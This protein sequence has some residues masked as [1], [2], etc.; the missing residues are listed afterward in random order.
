M[1]VAEIGDEGQTRLERGVARVG[2]DGFAHEI[3]HVYAARGGVGEILP[4][5]VDEAS[6]APPFL[7][8]PAARATVAGSRAA[9]AAMRDA[10]GLSHG[11]RSAPDSHRG[12]GAT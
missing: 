11:A 3:A 2:G 4:G 9:L 7:L 6:L 10:L 1:L 12:G 8:F 5:A